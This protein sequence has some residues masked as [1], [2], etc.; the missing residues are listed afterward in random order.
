MELDEKIK[1]LKE[2]MDITT[3]VQLRNGTI[4]MVF[5]N[6]FSDDNKGIFGTTVCISYFSEYKDDLKDKNGNVFFD[7]MKIR[8]P[9][10]KDN[11]RLVEEFFKE[12]LESIDI[13]WDW[14]RE[15]EPVT[16]DVS[17]EEI[18]A[19]LKEKYPN[20]EKFNLPIDNDK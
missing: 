14:E 15:E 13:D 5:L 4:G 7:I 18:N 11:Y 3:L 16:K 8:F 9:K 2:Q 17:L 6:N 1:S 19:L 20:V 10:G 12:E